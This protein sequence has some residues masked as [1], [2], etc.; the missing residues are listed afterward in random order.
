MTGCFMALSLQAGSGFQAEAATGAWKQDRGGWWYS[1]SDGSFAKKCWVKDSGKWYYFNADGY[2]VTGWKKITGKW[3]YF[4]KNGAMAT[5]WKK[6]AGKW[7]YFNKNGT[8]ATGWKKITGNWYYLSNGAMTTG[9]LKTGS[10]KYYF[11]ESG[12]AMSGW[13]TIDGKKYYFDEEKSAVTGNQTIY[14]ESYSFDSDGVL[15]E[16][17]LKVAKVGDLITFGHYEQDALDYNGDEPIEWIVL[18]KN[19]SGELLV[20]SRY[21]LANKD[22]SQEPAAETWESCTLRT[23]LNTGFINNAF[24]N[25]E[26]SKIRE[27]TVVSEKNA[28]YGT[29]G[30]K[31]TKDKVFILSASEVNKYFIGVNSGAAECKTTEYSI[32]RENVWT[33]EW[34][35]SEGTSKKKYD[36]N[37]LWW[38]RTPGFS[39]DLA[40][41]VNYDG[42]VVDYGRKVTSKKCG[43]R[44]VM[45]IKP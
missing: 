28:F 12:R 4:N 37:C 15:I 32:S 11:D 19:S 7:Y 16:E 8:M 27:T 34:A 17:P 25:S 29:D 33:Y 36:G 45:W 39:N 21:A 10:K 14:G 20:I 24:D 42:K 41:Y 31:N 35:K 6:I 18:D 38:L 3:Y 40:T 5:G 22:Y 1:Y 26:M 13:Q 30:G 23:W 2:M 43:V 9:W 44:P